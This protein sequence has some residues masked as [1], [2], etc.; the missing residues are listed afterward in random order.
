MV[1]EV[2]WRFLDDVEEIYAVKQ[3]MVSGGFWKVQNESWL[4]LVMAGSRG[5]K[6]STPVMQFLVL[7]HV[8]TTGALSEIALSLGRQQWGM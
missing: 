3:L 7:L 2:P 1:G 5:E 4:G 8:V 6:Y